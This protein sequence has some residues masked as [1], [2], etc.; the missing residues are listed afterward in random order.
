MIVEDAN[1][2]APKW[3]RPF[4]NFSATTED[5]VDSFVGQ[6]AASDADEAGP[7][8]LVSY[9]FEAPSLFFAI[10]GDSG[11]IKVRKSIDAEAFQSDYESSSSSN[12]NNGSGNNVITERLLVIAVDRGNPRLSSSVPV[13]IR[14][15][16]VHPSPPVWSKS[17]LWWH[18]PFPVPFDAI[19]GLNVA[20]VEAA[21]SVA[22]NEGVDVS[23]FAVGGNGSSVFGVDK[24]EGWISVNR[25]FSTSGDHRVGTLFTLELQAT[26]GSKIDGKGTD[27]VCRAVYR[28]LC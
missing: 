8:A 17:T 15:R 23:Y 5:E 9:S 18:R 21:A 1:D 14:V 6:V 13:E 20:R 4:Y 27:F 26:I 28:L 7:N 24:T 11:E 12:T 3:I 10:D 16:R 19:S 25:A 2:N 22:A